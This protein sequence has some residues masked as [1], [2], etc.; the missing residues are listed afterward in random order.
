MKNILMKF[1][2]IIVLFVFVTSCDLYDNLDTVPAQSLSDATAITNP[3]DAESALTGAYAALNQDGYYG[4][5]QII[6]GAN[7]FI[8]L[9]SNASTT[10]NSTFDSENNNVNPVDN[11]LL[12]TWDD[13][14]ELADRSS[15]V[16]TAVEL[17]DDAAFTEG[18]KE[19]LLA[20]ARFLRALAHFDALRFFGRFWESGSEDGIP[21][22]LVPGNTTNKDLAK[23]TVAESYASITGDLDFAIANAPDFTLSYRVSADAARA[24]R[25][26]VALYMEDY[27]TAIALVD[28][29]VP[30]FTLEANYG[31]IFVNRLS[32]S[33]LIFGMF[34]NATV[35]QSGHSFFF[36]SQ[37]NG[38]RQDY[39]PTAQFLNLIAGDPREAS[40]V[41]AVPEVLKY[42]NVNT[43]DDPTYIVR[44]AELHF[45]KAEALARQAAPDLEAAKDALFFVSDRVGLA[46]SAATTIA[47]F[48]DELQ[49][50]KVKEL[51][52]EGSHSWFDAIRLGNVRTLK[53][54]ITTDDRLILPFPQTEVDTNAAL[55][56]NDSY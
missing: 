17:L 20:E 29:V 45:I 21:L 33:E 24:L 15:N 56:Q 43:Q 30:N 2:Y 50:E 48:L 55:E 13:I 34:A 26:R 31:D 7:Q 40:I 18:R 36:I 4:R 32:S 37:A 41:N 44:L 35:E 16:I 52:F 39:A 53:S 6:W 5:M 23:A 54:S 22:R 38:G 42:P 11:T 12:G 14:Y 49:E 8:Y 9:G 28:D 46:R 27:A 47:E 3:N 51:A 10:R 1:T 25:A 19:G